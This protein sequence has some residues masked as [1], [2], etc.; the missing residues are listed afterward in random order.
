MV[1][2]PIQHGQYWIHICSRPPKYGEKYQHHNFTLYPNYFINYKLK[3]NQNTMKYY[4]ILETKIK[5]KDGHFFFFG[6]G[7]V[8]ED[9]EEKTH[10]LHHVYVA[11]LIKYSNI[12]TNISNSYKIYIYIYLTVW[13]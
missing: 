11:S 2:S 7:E 10:R 3:P 13:D 8:W 9:Y 12:P 6:E 4:I 5:S 1:N